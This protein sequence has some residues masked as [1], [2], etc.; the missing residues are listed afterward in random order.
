M[1]CIDSILA[2]LIVTPIGGAP[3]RAFSAQDCLRAP[4]SLWAC[5]KDI[6]GTQPLNNLASLPTPRPRGGG[7]PALRKQRLTY[8]YRGRLEGRVSMSKSS[9]KVPMEL[10]QHRHAARTPRAGV[11]ACRHRGPARLGRLCTCSVC[12]SSTRIGS[13]GTW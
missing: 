11:L 8:M 7:V 5:H 3:P 10:V 1:F 9:N 2:Y 6:C 4:G 12:E 13:G